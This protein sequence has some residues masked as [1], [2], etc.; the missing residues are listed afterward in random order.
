MDRADETL[1]ADEVAALLSGLNEHAGELRPGSLSEAEACVSAGQ[2]AEAWALLDGMLADEALD[3]GMREAASMLLGQAL[4]AE[5]TPQLATRHPAGSR[6]ELRLTSS[7]LAWQMRQCKT[8]QPL[9]DDE[10]VS[11]VTHLRD[12]TT[13]IACECRIQEHPALIRLRFVAGEVVEPLREQMLVWLNRLNQRLPV[14][15]LT[16]DADTGEMR[17]QA[18]F[19][20]LNAPCLPQHWEAIWQASLSVMKQIQPYLHRAGRAE[21]GRDELPVIALPNGGKSIP[22]PT[23]MLAGV[24]HASGAPETERA[25]MQVE[26]EIS[27]EWGYCGPSYRWVG[28]LVAH[29]APPRLELCLRLQQHT[30]PPERL[31]SVLAWLNRHNASAQL[32]S[33]FLDE[34]HGQ[35]MVRHS[36]PVSGAVL[37]PAHIEPLTSRTFG[38]HLMI[39]RAAHM[40]A[41]GANQERYENEANDN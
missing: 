23:Q 19:C 5:F 27:T 34:V 18:N 4:T 12:E 11:S 6:S 31:P 28:E 14:G 33:L 20:F 35:L 29:D 13:G 26:Y 16:L 8:I 30:I 40:D 9:I 41:L 1:T 32:G 24:Q 38:L 15:C 7:L 2:Y 39:P 17:L 22:A 36:L 21:E 37:L 3:S 10:A 25:A